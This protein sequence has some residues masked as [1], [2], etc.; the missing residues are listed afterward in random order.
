M[1][2]VDVDANSERRVGFTDDAQQ[3]AE[4][5]QPVDAHVHHQL[6][7][8]LEVKDVSVDERACSANIVY[9]YIER[10]F[11]RTPQGRLQEFSFGSA[12]HLGRPV[13]GPSKFWVGQQ[14]WCTWGRISFG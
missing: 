3:G 2:T 14:E 7:Q 9:V 10:A 8:F 12:S 5:H 4:V 13:K 1:E 6:L 11:S